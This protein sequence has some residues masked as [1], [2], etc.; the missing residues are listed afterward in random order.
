MTTKV[1]AIIPAYNEE[2][3][4]GEVVEETKKHVDEVIVVDDGSTDE[5]REEAERAGARDLLNQ[6]KKGYIG[7]IKTGFKEAKGDI[8][9]TLDGDG[10]HRPEDIPRLIAPIVRGEADLVLGS[11]EDP[12]SIRFSERLLNWLANFRVNVRD[13]GTGFRA[14]QRDLA[15]QLKLNGRC[16]CGIF[17]LEAAHLGAR[18]AEV[19]VSLNPVSKERGIAWGHFMQVLYLLPWLFKFKTEVDSSWVR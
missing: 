2:E 8:I 5:T 13:S 17:V 14:L 12:L 10:E 19:P 6:E 15:L 9:V 4:I 1:S 18:I 7:A 3:K 11:R 16:T